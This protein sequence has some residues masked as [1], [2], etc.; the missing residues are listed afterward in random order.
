MSL[1]STPPGE[2]PRPRT[3]ARLP[4]LAFEEYIEEGFA[5]EDGL[6]RELRRE[7]GRRGMPVIQVPPV[8][9]RAL[10]VLVAAAGARRVVEVGTL[11]GYSAIWM[12]RALPA[13]GRLV[14]L[15]RDEERAELAKEFIQRAGLAERVEVRV[16]EARE[17][18]E[19]MDEEGDV[20][21]VFVDADKDGNPM[22]ADEAARLLR[23]G[24]TLVVDNA[25]WRGGVLDPPG[26]MDPEARLISEFNGRM[27]SDERFLSTILTVGDGLL[28]A[29]RR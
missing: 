28:V 15:E 26:A 6:L 3:A 27:A 10:Q 9:A 20:D 4:A 16:G 18:L 25:L 29:V 21:L 5:S 19:A 8:S 2:A 14:T 22:Y 23:P 13:D 24:G 17:L 12:A 1:D 11:V 7:L